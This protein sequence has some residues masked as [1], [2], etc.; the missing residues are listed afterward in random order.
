M[1]QMFGTQQQTMLALLTK[2][3]DTNKKE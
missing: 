3:T 1:L 2:M